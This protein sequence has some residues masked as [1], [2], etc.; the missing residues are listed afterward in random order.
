MTEDAYPLSWPERWPKAGIRE[1]AKFKT[2][3]S[4]ARDMLVREITI[5]G[6]ERIVI[7]SNLKINKMG[8]PYADFK[9]PSDPGIAVYF[10]LFGQRQC[11]P[12]DKWN[13]AVDNMQAIR[14]CVEALRGIERWGAK[15]MVQASF[16]GF[17]ALPDYS[18]KNYF[19]GM[20]TSSAIHE[21][22]KELAKKIHP[23]AGGNADDFSQLTQEYQEALN[24][25][26]Y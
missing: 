11:I 9:E 1:R 8:L 23:D 19:E 5:M 16:M 14:C 25:C 13:K 4:R 26:R 17:K 7:S 15:E 18:K 22:Y 12:C 21:K 10:E 3:F 2:T 24:K 6:A 20:D